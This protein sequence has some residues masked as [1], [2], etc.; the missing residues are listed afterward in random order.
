MVDKQEE[1]LKIELPYSK[2]YDKDFSIK[3]KEQKGVIGPIKHNQDLSIL[4]SSNKQLEQTFLKT[5]HFNFI[6]EE[7]YGIPVSKK[8]INEVIL[9]KRSWYVWWEKRNKPKVYHFL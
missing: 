9:N 8:N 7:D 3:F 5:R 6:V 2:L 4:S 1:I